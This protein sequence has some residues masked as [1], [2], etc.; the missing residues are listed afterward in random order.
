MTRRAA[1]VA[2]YEQRAQ[3]G[4]PTLPRTSQP[5]SAPAPTRAGAGGA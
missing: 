4:L 3:H 5:L 1:R 2:A